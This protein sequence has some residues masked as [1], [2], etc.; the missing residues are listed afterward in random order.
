MAFS[1]IFVSIEYAK[2][3]IPFN[4][5]TTQNCNS[6]WFVVCVAYH[7]ND[8]DEANYYPCPRPTNYPTVSY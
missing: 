8:I 4:S 1:Y 3:E 5:I 7:V 2:L 6:H